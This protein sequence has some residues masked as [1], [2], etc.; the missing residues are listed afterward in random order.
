MAPSLL[1]TLSSALILGTTVSATQ[2]Y[3]LVDTYDSTN[4]LDKFGFFTSDYSTGDYNDV[5]P[6]S[7]YVNYQS[8]ENAQ[9]QGLLKIVDGDLY[10]GVDSTTTLD[11]AGVGRSSVRIESKSKYQKGLF[12]ADFSHFPKPTCGAWPAFWTVGSP[13][14]AAGE[15]DIVETWNLDNVNKVVIHTDGDIGECR[16]NGTGMTG[17]VS[18]PNCANYAAGQSDNEGCA[19]LDSSAPFGSAEGGVYA[20]EWTDTAIKVWGF[21]HANVPADIANNPNPDNWGTP[22]FTTS[23]CEAS[24]AQTGLTCEEWVANNPAAFA[25]VYFQLSSIKIYQMG[26]AS[27]TT[28]STSQIAS[29]TAVASTAVASEVVVSSTAAATGI[30]TESGAETHS[31]PASAGPAETPIADLP[32]RLAT[33]TVYQTNVKTITS[34]AP[35]VTNCP[36][37]ETPQIVT[38][39]VPL[40]TTI[41]PVV[42]VPTTMTVSKTEVHTI[43][44]CAPTVTNCPV[45]SKTT[46]T[47]EEVISTT[48]AIPVESYTKPAAGTTTQA[49]KPVITAQPP[50]GQITTYKTNIVTITSCPPT[51]TNCPV[52]KETTI[53][54][55]EVIPA[56]TVEGEKPVPVTTQ[57]P[58][59]PVV[60]TTYKTEV[61]TVTSCAPTVTNC[62]VGKETTIVT[63]AVI[64]TTAP[65]AGVPVT[66]VPQNPAVPGSETPVVPGTESPA[67]TAPVVPG[68]GATTASVPAAGQTNSAEKPV[69]ETPVDT[70]MPTTLV[71]APSSPYN[72][73]LPTG[74]FPT[75]TAAPCIG[76][77]CPATTTGPVQ[78]GADKLSSGAFMMAAALAVFVI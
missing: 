78:A 39:V 26:E 42:D 35:T 41:C 12:V 75:G 30:A 20:M 24:K 31:V 3:Q 53:I 74:L 67:T 64:T 50:A 17:T 48:A 16:I 27:N 71:V 47:K 45:G 36:A 5:D 40:T 2:S 72:G 46:V 76:S 4:F 60:L 55:S 73:T 21:T 28:L 18:K 6:T 66:N 13:W 62:P 52:G 49:E 68:T 8:A 44:S 57:A 58:D 70:A 69:A 29:S 56:T 19:G 37:R 22:S 33:S 65:A 32:T 51:V 25:D 23:V 9:A 15:I 63:S 10:L 77:A 14:P 38:E 59:V 34:C 11:P 7:G 54:T 1:S 61:H 43:T